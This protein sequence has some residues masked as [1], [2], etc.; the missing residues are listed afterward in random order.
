MSRFFDRLKQYFRCICI[1]QCCISVQ[2]DMEQNYR[3]NSTTESTTIS[4]RTTENIIDE[5]EA[6][7]SIETN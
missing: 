1:L 3:I 7:L 6:L 4:H 5:V 2:D